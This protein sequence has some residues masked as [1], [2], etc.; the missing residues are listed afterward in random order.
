MVRVG[1]TFLVWG[2]TMSSVKG[3]NSQVAGSSKLRDES[4]V[5]K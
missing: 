3:N 5:V 4:G 2:T 1:I